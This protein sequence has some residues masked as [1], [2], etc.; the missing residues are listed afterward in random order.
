MINL[1]GKT[2]EKLEALMLE[3]GQSKF[4]AKQLFTWIYEKKE[5]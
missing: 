1:Y 3:E 2:L 5:V 4:R